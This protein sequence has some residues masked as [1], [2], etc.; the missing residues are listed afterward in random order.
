MLNPVQLRAHFR[1]DAR[2]FFPAN[3]NIIR[4]FD[5]GVQTGFGVDGAAQSRCGSDHQLRHFLR[6]QIGSKQKGKP[7]PFVR[8]RNPF[9]S[10]PAAAFRLRFCKNDDAFLHAV[11]CE[12]FNHVIC[13]RRLLEHA[14][15]AANDFRFIEARKQIVRVQHVRDAN[16]PVA[17]MGSGLDVVAEAA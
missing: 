7:K 15:V 1:K 12:L 16:E 9:S 8:G 3:Q 14:D 4:P 6:A 13:R 2:D 10:K 11:A 5:F 17:G